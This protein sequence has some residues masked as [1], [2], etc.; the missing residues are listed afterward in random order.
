MNNTV[1]VVINNGVIDTIV[2]EREV[3]VKILDLD[4]S[5]VDGYTVHPVRKDELEVVQCIEKRIYERQK[6]S[7]D[8]SWSQEDDYESEEE[9]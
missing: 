2:A 9:L 7:G 5:I 3:R 6:E 1:T 8:M 4:N